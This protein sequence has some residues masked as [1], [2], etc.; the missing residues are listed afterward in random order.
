[1]PDQPISEQLAIRYLLG[2]LSDEESEHLDELSVTD[3]DFAQLLDNVENDLVDQYA[4]GEL[5]NDTLE[6][7]KTYY[8]SSSK[9]IEK[10]KFAQDF[11]KIINKTAPA[12]IFHL[13]PRRLSMQWGFAAAALLLLL[14]VGYL[15]FENYSL[16]NEVLRAKAE[17]SMLKK[18]EQELQRQLEQQRS[19]DTEKA[20]ELASVRERLKQLEQQLEGNE[21]RKVPLLAFNLTP[22]MRGI[23]IPKFTLPRETESV[24]FTL[25]LESNEYRE[26]QAALKNPST[27]EVL[28]RSN[29]VKANQID[30]VKIILPANLLKTQNYL[31]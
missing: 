13:K 15:I 21:Q 14:T 18:R 28:W 12:K 1:M 20:N 19:V 30:T 23:K 10:V 27:D 29:K 4:R 25:A 2:S 16:R 5:T 11:G 3:N 7:F 26:Y 24:E 17:Q 6:K 22:Q 8:L 31:L 9:R